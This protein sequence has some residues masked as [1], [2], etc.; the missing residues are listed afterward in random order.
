MRFIK[1][2]IAKRLSIM[3][4]GLIIIITTYI[5]IAD[6][7]VT[8]SSDKFLYSEVNT[9]P[10]NKVGVLLGTSKYLKNGSINEY[11]QN[12][13]D[14]CVDLYK[15]GKISAIIVSGDNSHREY[16]EPTDMKNE[17]IKRGVADSAIYLDYAGF[18]TFDSMIRANK[19]F[20]QDS[21]TVISQKFHNQRAV[22]IARHFNI[23]AI[24]FN[25]KDVSAYNGFKTK[26]REKIARGRLFIDMLIDKQPK[27]LGKNI[28][29]K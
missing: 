19:V 28:E 20:G 27:F 13:I 9:V 8:K 18:R 22:Y 25:A 1:N 3:I 14:A 21:F 24:G 4:I 2:K 6:F 29:I 23:N 10:R 7:I 5:F 11:W 17:L 16:D 26:V 12:R 15:S